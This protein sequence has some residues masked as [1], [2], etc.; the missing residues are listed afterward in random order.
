[1]VTFSCARE[2]GSQA[3]WRGEN[4]SPSDSRE[5]QPRREAFAQRERNAWWLAIC[6][7]GRGHAGDGE[8]D[9]FQLL[10]TRH[11]WP[12]GL[13]RAIRR[14]RRAAN[15]ITAAIP[16]R[17]ARCS[18]CF[19]ALSRRIISAIRLAKTARELQR[20]VLGNTA[21]AGRIPEPV[22]VA[23]ARAS[24]RGRPFLPTAAAETAGA[25]RQQASTTL[26]RGGD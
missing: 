5:M 19:L 15:V 22:A 24:G 18:L 11:E 10:Q 1:M 6:G 4:T 7:G 14:Q 26:A 12:E 20:V 13:A 21:R 3:S 23:M 17:A 16:V 25:A 2:G 8:T 9:Q